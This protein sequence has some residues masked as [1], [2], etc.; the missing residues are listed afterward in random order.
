[1]RRITLAPPDL[2][3]AAFDQ[4]LNRLPHDRAADFESRD[5]AVFRRQLGLWRQ[6]AVSDIAGQNKFDAFVERRSRHHDNVTS[7]CLGIK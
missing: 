1:M 4:I 6:G 5:Q 7:L 2:D 3:D